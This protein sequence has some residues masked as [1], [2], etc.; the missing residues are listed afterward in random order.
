MLKIAFHPIY[1]YSLPEGHHFPME[2]Y[3]LLP[4]QLLHEGTCKPENFFT[5]LTIATVAVAQRLLLA[6]KGSLML[7]MKYSQA[8]SQ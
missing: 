6:A 7:Y 1:K 5:Y 3:E 8:V 2:K 4:Q